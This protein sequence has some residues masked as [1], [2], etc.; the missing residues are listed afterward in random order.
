MSIREVSEV[1][2]LI[3]D[4]DLSGAGVKKLLDSASATGCTITVDS[5]PY[6]DPH[7]A[8]TCDFIKVTIP[9]SNG[10]THGGKRRTL[11]IVGRLGA[12]QAQ[13]ER[14]GMV[15]DSDGS[16]VALAL[17]L[18]LLRMHQ[19]GAILQGDVIITTHVATHVSITE[20]QPVEFHGLACQLR[21]NE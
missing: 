3:D 4:P 19:A 17:A 16:I 20:H 1:I 11:G 14:I 21:D 18:K 2:N 5:V 10:K 15:S 6:D 12:Q 8:F 7:R 13:P 9:G